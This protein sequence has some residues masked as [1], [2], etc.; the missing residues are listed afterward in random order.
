MRITTLFFDLDGTLLPMDQDVFVEDYFGRLAKTA[1]AAGYDPK[2]CIRAVGAGVSAMVKNDGSKTNEE[3]FWETFAAVM[4]GWKM[5]DRPIFDRFYRTE[6][7]KVQAVCG[8]NP[9]AKELVEKAKALGF[10]VVLATN[11]L[12]PSVATENRIRWA[13]FEPEDFEAYTTYEHCR[14]CKPNPDYYREL[15]ELMK[16]QPEECLMVGNDL[17]EDMVAEKLGMKVFLLTDCLINKSGTDL[18]RY[19]HGGF[20]ELSRFVDALADET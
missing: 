17:D 6:F 4:S 5:E 7:Q 15:L 16:L 11:P 3:A 14:Y 9:A 19:P 12:F 8:C 1:A 18:S 2:G 13:G 20:A 10:R